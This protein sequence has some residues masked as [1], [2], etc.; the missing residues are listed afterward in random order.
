MKNMKKILALIVAVLMIVASMSVAFAEDTVI[1][2]GAVQND[3]A[4][5]HQ[6][7]AYRI[8]SGTV[9]VDGKTLSDVQYSTGVSNTL[10]T[11]LKGNTTLNAIAEI[12]ALN[13]TDSTARDVAEALGK[14]TTAAA[15]EALADVLNTYFTTTGSYVKHV[16]G[17]KQSDGSYQI[18]IGTDLGYYFI[19]DD[20]TS[21]IDSTGAPTTYTGNTKY[22]L[23]VI[24]STNIA[25]KFSVPTIEKKI[26]E[27]SQK[28]DA[29]SKSVGDT[30]HYQLTSTVPDISEY[31]AY[32]F[33]MQDDISDG[34]TLNKA[35][36]P[37]HTFTIKVGETELVE[38][39]D[40]T[41]TY[42]SSDAD[43]FKIKFTS[44]YDRFK[45]TAAADA[46][47]AAGSAITV[48]YSAT[49]NENAVIGE[50]GNPNK[51]KL[52]YTNDA[53]WDGQGT[54]GNPDGPTGETPWDVVNT[55]I[56]EIDILKIDGDTQLPLEGVQF[57]IKGDALEAVVTY[58]VS[59]QE[60]DEN[61][62]TQNPA[63]TK[64]YLLKDGTYTTSQSTAE[65]AEYYDTDAAN[66]IFARVETINSTSAKAGD[67]AK[68]TMSSGEDGVIKFAGLGAGTYTI[69]EEATLD[70]YNLLTGDITVGISGTINSNA[71][72]AA[73][74][75]DGTELIDWD[76]SV[77]GA[78]SSAVH[79][80]NNHIVITVEN[81]KG[82]TLPSTGGMGTTILYIGGS[83]LV[84]AAAILLITKRRMNAE[85]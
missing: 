6:Y 85:D 73:T 81:N 3:K 4:V 7:T 26:V 54:T 34:L 71:V 77:T 18:N 33:I 2:V 78:S 14:V 67:P 36:A 69:H 5:N 15:K 80:D 61:F 16:C 62:W 44:L 10:I 19:R 1:T 57:S 28:F 79:S 31:K 76:Y 29:N 60:K 66:K 84:L 55:Y 51:A 75:T 48:D 52:I 82:A 11:S 13:T 68:I 9:S 56:T 72:S 21:Y 63:E 65:T 32:T 50:G 70:G 37:A 41:V 59:F 83:I 22:V 49:I 47:F 35:T 20:Q 53:N 38:G 39:T 27:G 42:D 30:V 40:Y 17:D 64:Y 46:A 43:D 23:Q 24:G 8:F 45:S 74:I 12:A 25:P 58:N